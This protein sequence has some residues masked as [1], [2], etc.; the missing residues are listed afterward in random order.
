MDKSA[1]SRL[2]TFLGWDLD[3]LSVN[4]TSLPP[5]TLDRFAA[6]AAKAT[7]WV[8]VFGDFQR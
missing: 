4:A 1:M 6:V 8:A 2:G 7:A 3:R 5:K